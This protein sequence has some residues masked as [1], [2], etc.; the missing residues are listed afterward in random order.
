[1]QRVCTLC[2]LQQQEGF[3]TLASFLGVE[4]RSIL[5][6][7]LQT[8]V[9]ILHAK[10]VSHLRDL[11]GTIMKRWMTL[12]SQA[13]DEKADTE[14]QSALL[15]LAYVS[16]R[17]NEVNK[18]QWM[19]AAAAAT[20]HNGLELLMDTLK[21]TQN[22]DTTTLLVNAA[23]LVTVLCR[24]D[25]FRVRDPNAV[26]PIVSS[27][28][29]HVLEFARAGA[30]PI[31]FALAQRTSSENEEELFVAALS[32][33][34]VL[35]IQDDIVQSMVAVG[36]LKYIPQVLEKQQRQAVAAATLGLVRNLCANDE[37]KTTLCMGNS[38]DQASIVPGV[39][40]A[41]QAFPKHALLQ[42]HACGTLAAM[43][44]RKPRNSEYIVEQSGHVCIISA[45]RQHPQVVLVQR[46]GALAL[47]NLASRSGNTRE[48][49]LDSGAEAVLHEAGKHQ[50]SVDEA[51]AALRDLGV[52]IKLLKIKNG[53]AV[54]R[55]AMFGESKPVFR[56]V[57][58]ESN[59]LDE[60]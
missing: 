18:T 34:R 15:E 39:L 9:T 8:L 31:L 27:A 42:E 12:Y 50:A 32:A 35:A 56:P 6:Q 29:D 44:L 28:H 45:M 2:L 5:L 37:V 54:E 53:N 11:M 25:D 17:A 14:L 26:G 30:V 21:T 49:L 10:N 22:A 59:A 3:Y 55:T 41:M 40:A 38:L 46:Q 48:A 33:L 20:E 4:D 1:M 57:F 43:A 60:N 24:F 13:R 52:P 47:R 36:V 51:Y 7:T 58:E 16:C 23:K 19:K